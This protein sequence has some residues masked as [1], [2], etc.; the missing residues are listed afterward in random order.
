MYQL[1]FF[2]VIS[3]F[4]NLILQSQATKN[5]LVWENEGRMTPFPGTECDELYEVSTLIGKGKCASVHLLTSNCSSKQGSQDVEATKHCTVKVKSSNGLGSS[6]DY[7]AIKIFQIDYMQSF[8]NE[9]SI[10]EHL[11]DVGTMGKTAPST[12]YQSRNIG[13]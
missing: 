4:V 6:L 7:L 12:A 8:L 1:F 3:W 10:L 2:P 11:Q 9:K 5:Y 13:N